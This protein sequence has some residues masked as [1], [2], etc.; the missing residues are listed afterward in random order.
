MPT[1]RK[2]LFDLS[3]DHAQG[4]V[5]VRFQRNSVEPSFTRADLEAA[6]AKAREEGHQAGLAEAAA[7]FDGRLAQAAEALAAGLAGL[8]AKEEEIRRATET[9]AVELLRAVTAKAVPALARKEPLA[10]L[11]AMVVDCLREAADEPRIVLR[12]APDLFEPMRERLDAIAQ[13]HGFAGKFVLLVDES[14]G[15]VDGRLE[16]ADGGAER[17]TRRLAQDLDAALARTLLNPISAPEPS[18]E[19]TPHE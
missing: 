15:P 17:N 11:E 5:A 4:P 8:A 12:I 18:R 6:C 14:L 3:F 19:E 13:S 7:G 1:P 2:Y 10:D 9:R 16:W